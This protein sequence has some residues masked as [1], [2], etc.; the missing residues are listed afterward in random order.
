MSEAKATK[1]L[2]PAEPAA[3]R[4]RQTIKLNESTNE[5]TPRRG[6]KRRTDIGDDTPTLPSPIKGEGEDYRKE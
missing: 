3:T 5:A 2:K 6:I 4:P 1:A